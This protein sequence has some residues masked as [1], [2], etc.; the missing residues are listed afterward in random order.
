MTNILAQ[1]RIS[2]YRIT[3]KRKVGF[4]SRGLSREEE[5]DIHNG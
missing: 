5:A 2:V 4:G 1:R 3:S